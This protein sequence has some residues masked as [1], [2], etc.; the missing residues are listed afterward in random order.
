MG[1]VAD[2]AAIGALLASTRE[3]FARRLPARIAEI[4][5]WIG[6]DAWSDAVR[7]AHKLRGSASTYGFSEVGRVAGALEE[8]LRAVKE[9]ADRATRQRLL[10]LLEEGRDQAERA[11]T[12]ER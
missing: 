10:S 4:A 8:E 3:E 2:A 7:A 12:S 9:T 1:A 5:D 11:C 6:Q